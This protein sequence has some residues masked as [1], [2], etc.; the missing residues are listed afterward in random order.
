[1]KI[2]SLNDSYDHLCPQCYPRC[3]CIGNL[4]EKHAKAEQDKVKEDK[5]ISPRYYPPQE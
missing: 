3:G 1:M 5:P 4:C 2:P